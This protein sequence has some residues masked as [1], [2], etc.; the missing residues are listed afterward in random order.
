[1]QEAC[2][3]AKSVITS[4][5]MDYPGRA[6]IAMTGSDNKFVKDVPDGS[7]YVLSTEGH[8][9]AFSGKA[10][11]EAKALTRVNLARARMLLEAKRARQTKAPKA[12]PNQAS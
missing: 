10:A 3:L 4:D 12:Q 9:F 1:M 6:H 8:G 5:V 11:D 2:R 7:F